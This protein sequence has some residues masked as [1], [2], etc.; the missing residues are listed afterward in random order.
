M[1]RRPAASPTLRPAAVEPVKEM[2]RTA[3]ASTSA[4]PASA[5]PGRTCS[6]TVGKACLLE[7]ASQHVAAAHRR[8]RVGL[9]Q[10]GVAE[11]QRR[12]HRADGEDE[13]EVERRDHPHDPGGH[14]TGQRH[15]RLRGG[16]DLAE[17]VR[18]QR[19][20]LVALLRRRVGLELR[21]RRDRAGLP[22]EPVFDLGGMCLEQVTCPPKHCRTLLVRRPR[23]GPLRGRRGVGR[24]LD[25]GGRG[26]L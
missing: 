14:A 16:Q 24:G 25:V 15:P 2:I 5:P 11:R 3:G 22:H 21:L 9:E 12:G 18:R 23:P 19:G 4:A 20:R 17:R 1:S 26:Q 7:D 8:A 6:T 13:R 10:H